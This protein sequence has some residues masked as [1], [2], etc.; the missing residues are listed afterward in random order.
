[1]HF[2]LTNHTGWH[3]SIT[4]PC[5]VY[6]VYYNIHLKYFLNQFESNFFLAIDD[7]LKLNSN[8]ISFPND[9]IDI[10]KNIAK[11]ILFV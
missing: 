9:F 2:I 3:N 5:E 6:T 8:T 4:P 7:A 11:I 10:Q 1:M